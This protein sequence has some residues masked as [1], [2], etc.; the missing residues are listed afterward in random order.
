MTRRTT[1]C[2]AVLA[3]VAIALSTLAAAQQYSAR[4]SGDVVQLTDGKAQTTVSIVPSVG[5][6]AFELRVKGTNVLR[7]P[8]ASVTD[9]KAKPAMSGIPFMGPWA[10]RLDETAFYANGRKYAFDLTLGNVRGPIPIHGFVTTTDQWRVVD[11]N[12]N[13]ASAWVTSRLDFSRQ[14]QWMKQ[15]PFAHTIEM[16]YRLQDGVLEVRTAITNQSAEPMPVAIGFHPYY[17]L[18]DSPRDDW[19]IGVG[20][21]TRWLLAPN[22]LPTGETEPIEKLFPNPLAAPLREYNLDDVFADLVRDKR[23][24]ATMTIA[25][26]A[27]RLEI[28]LGPNYRSVVIWAPK[29][30]DFICIEPMAAITDAINLA[31]RGQYKELQS[32]P[33][34]GTWRESF[35]IRPIGF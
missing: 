4:Q 7:W 24:R 15:W 16:T 5:N 18:T 27:Q 8:Y 33:P 19:K 22:N 25:G 21:R 13:A 14:P 34:G 32:I 3:V 26:N 12:A 30:R 6:I 9:F 29:D 23:D 31:H 17:R 35:W 1:Q 2:L 10:N 28:E 11:A 20:A